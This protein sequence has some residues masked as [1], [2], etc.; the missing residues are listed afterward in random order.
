M[1][2]SYRFFQHIYTCISCLSS[3]FDSTHC[4][5]VSV[6]CPLFRFLVFINFSFL[7]FWPSLT[8]QPAILYSSIFSSSFSLSPAQ[9]YSITYGPTYQFQAA[10]RATGGHSAAPGAKELRVYKQ[11]ADIPNVIVCWLTVFLHHHHHHH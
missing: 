10:S 6:F 5:C 4:F 8:T 1:V 11:I 3:I 7:F 9:S 2:Q